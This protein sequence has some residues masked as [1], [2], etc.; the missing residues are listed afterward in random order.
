MSTEDLLRWM[1]A[2]RQQAVGD[3]LAG[4]IAE[5][6]VCRQQVLRTDP[7]QA[8]EGGFKH[9]SCESGNASAPSTAEAVSKN[10]AAN[11]RRSDWG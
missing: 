8:A 7:H 2:D 10:V 5:C 6:V 3:W 11:A 9:V 4:S 1:P